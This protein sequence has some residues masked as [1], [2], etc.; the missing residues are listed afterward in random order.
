MQAFSQQNA[1]GQAGQR[2]VMR[3]ALQPL[4]LLLEGGDVGKDQ[5]EIDHPPVAVAHRA[6]GQ[7]FRKALA[8]FPQSPGFTAPV[9][10]LNQLRQC[11]FEEFRL[12][13]AEKPGEE[14]A[15]GHVFGAVARQFAGRRI[16]LDQLPLRIGDD[17]PFAGFGKYTGGQLQRD[18]GTLAVGYFSGGAPVAGKA[19]LGI[20]HGLATHQ[21]VDD[22][23]I[24]SNDA[25]LEI[26][27]DLVRGQNGAVALPLGFGQRAGEIPEVFADAVHGHGIDTR[28]PRRVTGETELAVL[29]PV[30]VR[31]QFQEAAKAF[32]RGLQRVDLPL[33][34][35]RHPVERR[36]HPAD[37]ILPGNRQLDV[38]A[39]G[40]YRRA[41]L[42]QLFQM[43]G[44]PE[45]DDR[46]ER[47]GSQH[48][49]RGNR[50]A[51][52]GELPTR[53]VDELA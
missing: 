20:V 1:I 6:G 33:Y 5:D 47:P 35:A 32:F 50:Q 25:K 53:I 8:I 39:T 16:H 45:G 23:A 37:F 21:Q 18:F 4:L 19:A 15:V 49:Y 41:G 17:D 51:G 22:L 9:A 38:E 46:Q 30:P 13:C 10:D 36:S 2:I 29:L 44:Q 24:R 28:L 14:V 7:Q 26:A 3:H 48:Q 42:F 43:T 34:L 12:R 52:A 40:R 11:R 27:E 31:G